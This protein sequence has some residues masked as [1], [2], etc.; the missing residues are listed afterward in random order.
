MM[1]WL[2]GENPHGCACHGLYGKNPYRYDVI[3][4]SALIKGWGGEGEPK[5]ERLGDI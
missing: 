5:S 2:Y 1:S 3:G 4:C